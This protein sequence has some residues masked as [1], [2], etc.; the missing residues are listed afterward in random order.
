MAV[1]CRCL[2]VYI[3]EIYE[4]AGQ[5]ANGNLYRGLKYLCTQD[6]LEDNN[7]DRQSWSTIFKCFDLHPSITADIIVSLLWYCNTFLE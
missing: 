2:Y 4:A 7:T 1:F 6:L 5:Q 3:S